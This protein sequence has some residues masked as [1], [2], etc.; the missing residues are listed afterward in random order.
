MY[1]LP[2]LGGSPYAPSAYNN[3]TTFGATSSKIIPIPATYQSGYLAGQGFPAENENY[4]MYWITQAINDISNDTYNIHQ[5]LNNLLSGASISPN[6]GNGQVLSAV[7][8]LISSLGINFTQ[9]A[10]TESGLT[11]NPSDYYM[12]S[13]AEI[14]ISHQVGEDLYMNQP[15]TQVYIGIERSTANPGF[16][17]YCP[18]IERNVDKVITSAMAPNL[19]TA[20]RAM[21]TS[22]LGS[23]TVAVTCSASNV[24]FPN[25]TIGNQAINMLY[26]EAL[27]RQWFVSQDANFASSGPLPSGGP[28]AMTINIS[29]VDY[30]ITGISPGTRIVT[31]SGTPTTGNAIFYP[32]RINGSTT[33]IQLPKLAGFVPVSSGDVDATVVDGYRNKIGRAHV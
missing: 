23:T 21:Q 24:T 7:Q 26:N 4:L 9:T 32:Y 2:T 30:V 20:L 27:V 8:G 11:W 31:V 33:S 12:L 25:S 22:I 19:V 10:V 3:Q 29:G 18:V 15:L 14:A 17:Q 1:S 16:P 5:E 13:K 6:G 28:A